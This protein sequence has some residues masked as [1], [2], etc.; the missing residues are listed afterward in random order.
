MVTADRWLRPRH[1]L[2]QHYDAAYSTPDYRIA[3]AIWLQRQL[4]VQELPTQV[5][6]GV[7]GLRLTL[8]PSGIRDWDIFLESSVAPAISSYLRSALGG[9]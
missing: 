9:N 8:S 4:D 1:V 7:S 3:Q 2:I 5:L 6:P